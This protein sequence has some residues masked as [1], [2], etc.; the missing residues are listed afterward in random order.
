MEQLRDIATLV[1]R[2]IVRAPVELLR[3]IHVLDELR[4]RDIPAVLEK[5]RGFL[6]TYTTPVQL[7]QNT[8]VH[9][10]PRI[11]IS[12][13]HIKDKNSNTSTCSICQENFKLGEEEVSQ[14][15]CG[16]IFH[17]SCLSEWFIYKNTCPLC[18]RGS[19]RP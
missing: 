15:H 19:Q 7:M 10:M 9:L 12:E 16:H 3:D 5:N 14:M 11:T 2:L 17:T 13:K 4:R 8:P 18:R 1:E 6:V